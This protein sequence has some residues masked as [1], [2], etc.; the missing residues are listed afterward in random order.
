MEKRNILV[1]VAIIVIL[2]ITYGIVRTKMDNAA[3]S[4]VPTLDRST[5]LVYHI[6]NA[7]PATTTSCGITRAVLREIGETDDVYSESLNELFKGPTAAEEREG[8]SSVVDPLKDYFDNVTFDGH[9]A[10]INFNSE[11][12]LKTLNSTACMQEAVKRPIE[13][14]LNQFSEIE[15]IEYSINGVTFR[16]WDA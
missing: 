15:R 5:I 8:L 1:V 2:G 14:T 11:E 16:E 13:N 3:V 7:N 12:A 6:D 10:F 4:V 9:T